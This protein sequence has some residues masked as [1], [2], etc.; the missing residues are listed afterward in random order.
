MGSPAGLVLCLS[1]T[2]G[3]HKESGSRKR[4]EKEE[5]DEKEEQGERVRRR[6][7]KRREER[8]KEEEEKKREEE[9]KEKG[10]EEEHQIS[11]E[12]LP[13]QVA[14]A[15]WRPPSDTPSIIQANR[16]G[17]EASMI[18]P[19]TFV[20]TKREKNFVPPAYSLTFYL[21]ISRSKADLVQLRDGSGFGGTV[22][23]PSFTIN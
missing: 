7:E 23:A 17:A 3:P 18:V 1:Q 16:P 5:E 15:P 11:R 14:C 4:E 8:R 21:R 20:W 6:R 9:R 12:C 22:Q 13:P 2:S 10:E 19:L